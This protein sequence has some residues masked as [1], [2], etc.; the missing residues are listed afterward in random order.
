MPEGQESG[1]PM[2]IRQW[3]YAVLDVEGN[4]QSRHGPFPTHRMQEWYDQGY[5][6]GV[7]VSEC[8]AGGF[9]SL[10]RRIT[11]L[12]VM[13]TV[14]DGFCLG[15]CYQALD[16]AVHGP[17]AIEQ[18][19]E[20]HG[21]GYFPEGTLVAR[22]SFGEFAL[23]GET[24]PWS[25]TDNPGRVVAGPDAPK[26]VEKSDV[27]EEAEQATAG[28]Q[29]RRREEVEAHAGGADEADALASGVASLNIHSAASDA[30]CT[31][32]EAGV[33]AYLVLDTCV[34]LDEQERDSIEKLRIWGCTLVVP[35]IVLHE[36]DQKRKSED[37][38][39][40]K[41]SRAAIRYCGYVR[42]LVA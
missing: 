12:P 2:E 39:L 34:L 40:S 4:E 25:A 16:G 22:C 15:L 6:S 35:Q 17:Y 20:W 18:M 24:P 26:T 7:L 23:L 11:G 38:V 36:T 5:L 31:P 8:V 3:C 13:A 41:S 19:E 28:A 14:P 32:S 21:D 1:A 9:Q 27:L 29:P 42:A 33:Y 10:G 37:P 30:C